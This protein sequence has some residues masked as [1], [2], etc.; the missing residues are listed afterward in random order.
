MIAREFEEGFAASEYQSV[1]ADLFHAL[2]QPL[3]TL[4]CR[5]AASLQKPQS[6]GRSRRDLQ[7]ALRQTKSVVFLTAAIRELVTCE[8]R[9]EPPPASDLMACVKEVVDDLRPVA[10]SADLELSLTCC[11]PCLVKL[12]ASRLRQ[13]VFYLLDSALSHS[14]PGSEINV[15]IVPANHEIGLTVRISPPPRAKLGGSRKQGCTD[16]SLLHRRLTLAIARRTLESAFGSFRIH[17]ASRQTTLSIRLPRSHQE[18]ALPLAR[19]SQ[20]CG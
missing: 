8:A 19:P 1:L 18:P 2:S 7:M 10:R 20:R 5:L 3:T 6:A 4:Q 11:A 15:S 14:R 12:D 17:Y 13:A 16:I 9:H